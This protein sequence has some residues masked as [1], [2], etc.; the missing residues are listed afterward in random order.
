MEKT[1]NFVLKVQGLLTKILN[2][3]NDPTLILKKSL[4][5]FEDTICKKFNAKME[6]SLS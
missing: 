5:V 6:E 4:K 3:F 2:N 1:N